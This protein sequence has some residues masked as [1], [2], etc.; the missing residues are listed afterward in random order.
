[1]HG[2]RHT[3]PQVEGALTPEVE[4]S[5]RGCGHWRAAPWCASSVRPRSM[6]SAAGDQRPASPSNPRGTFPV[7]ALQPGDAA[8][9]LQVRCN[10]PGA[11]APSMR[12]DQE[13]ERPDGVPL[14]LQMG[15]D[16]TVVMGSSRIKVDNTNLLQEVV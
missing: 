2:G 3:R 8:E 15:A 13:V 16:L 1:M 14:L 12:G 10:Q 9:L 7:N 6:R 11:A 4:A 5:R